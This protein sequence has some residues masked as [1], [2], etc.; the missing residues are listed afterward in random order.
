LADKRI[1]KELVPKYKACKNN[2]FE[3]EAYEVSDKAKQIFAFI[4]KNS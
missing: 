3:K 1:F 4:L 2:L